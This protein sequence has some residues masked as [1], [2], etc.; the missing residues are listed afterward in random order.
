MGNLLRAFT[1]IV[2][3]GHR[4]IELKSI[5][6][7]IS[8][9]QVFDAFWPLKVPASHYKSTNSSNIQTTDHLTNQVIFGNRYRLV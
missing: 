4:N 5:P 2:L 3:Y 8:E 7:I 6:E 1:V 9:M